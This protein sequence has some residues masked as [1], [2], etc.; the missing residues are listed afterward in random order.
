MLG[1]FI[2]RRCSLL[3]CMPSVTGYLWVCSICILSLTAETTTCPTVI[4]STGLL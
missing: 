4:L 2:E 1:V 3:N